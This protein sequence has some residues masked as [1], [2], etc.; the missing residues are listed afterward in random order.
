MD[1]TA[2]IRDLSKAPLAGDIFQLDE[3][4]Y[5]TV[6]SVGAGQ[7]K[8]VPGAFEPGMFR[9]APEDLLGSAIVMPY[10]TFRKWLASIAAGRRVDTPPPV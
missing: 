5:I 4:A 7:V 8:Y 2:A 9:D 1:Q 10:K 3:N 6:V